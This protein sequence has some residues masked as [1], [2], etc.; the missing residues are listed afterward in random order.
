MELRYFDLLD[1]ADDDPDV[2]AI[3]TRRAGFLCGDGLDRA[4]KA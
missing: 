2:R 3:G 4:E 1:A